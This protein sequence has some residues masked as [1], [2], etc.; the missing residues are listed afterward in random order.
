MQLSHSQEIFLPSVVSWQ[1]VQDDTQLV[2]A[3]QQGN[4][5][6]FAF[7]VQRHQRCV[8]NLV[9]RMLQ[10]Y[11][12]ACAITQDAFLAV[13]QGLPS[14]RE[15]GCFTT[16][17]Y[18]IAYN[19][20]LKQLQRRKRERALHTVMVAEQMRA[21]FTKNETQPDVM[22]SKRLNTQSRRRNEKP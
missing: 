22:R 4:Q 10:V 13:W 9:L 17:L 8:F 1:T 12:E 5:D 19:Y 7:L 20:A 14:F 3:S 11:E 6:A 18:R 16:W 2:K 21:G 15:E